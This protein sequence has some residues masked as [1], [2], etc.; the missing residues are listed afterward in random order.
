[1]GERQC[2]FAVIERAD[3]YTELVEQAQSV[4]RRLR[5]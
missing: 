2:D 4:L 3:Q 1:V 5:A